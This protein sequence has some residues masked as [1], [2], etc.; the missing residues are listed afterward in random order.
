MAKPLTLMSQLVGL[1]RV[2]GLV[3]DEH[4]TRIVLHAEVDLRIDDHLPQL[5]G[6]GD[7]HLG[8]ILLISLGE[9]LAQRQ[10]LRCE[11]VIAQRVGFVG[12]VEH[13]EVGM[14]A[15]GLLIVLSNE[16]N[17]SVDA[18]RRAE[19]LVH[20]LLKSFGNAV[21]LVIGHDRRAIEHLD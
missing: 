5:V 3:G 16:T 1:D 21:D 2:G 19:V 20:G 17:L 13:D 18:P 6:D 10:T 8:A 9:S 15:P 11:V 4:A 14:T 12:R 7:R